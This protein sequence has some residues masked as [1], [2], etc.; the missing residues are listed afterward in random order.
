ML[1]SGAVGKS[2]LTIRYVSD[3]FVDNYDPTIEDSYRKMITVKG[4]R[5]PAGKGISGTSWYINLNIYMYISVLKRYTVILKRRNYDRTDNQRV[6]IFIFK[7]LL[8]V[9]F[10]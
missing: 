8:L 3:Q 2:A 4:K 9:Y 5:R 1:G 10:W 7:L 6:C